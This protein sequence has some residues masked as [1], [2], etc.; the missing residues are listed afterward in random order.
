[1]WS[2]GEMPV[3]YQ[4]AVTKWGT[5]TFSNPRPTYPQDWPA[6]NAAQTSEKDTFSPLLARKKRWTSGT[7]GRCG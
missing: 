3:S 4:A 7:C 2:L 6:Y 1:M 5:E